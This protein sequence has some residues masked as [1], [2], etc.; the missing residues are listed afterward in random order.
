[1]VKNKKDH[2]H[3]WLQILGSADFDIVE[4]DEMEENF[5][6]INLVDVQE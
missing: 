5:K 6:E 2:S 3:E 1:M 4:E